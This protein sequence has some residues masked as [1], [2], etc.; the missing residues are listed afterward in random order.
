MSHPSG[1]ARTDVLG[2]TERNEGGRKKH[3]R[4]APVDTSL[5]VTPREQKR[6]GE[7]VHQR[8]PGVSPQSRNRD[9][10]KS[11][12][13]KKQHPRGTRN[14]LR[15]SWGPELGIT[16]VVGVGVEYKDQ[17]STLLIL[18]GIRKRS[19]GTPVSTGPTLSDKITVE[20]RSVV[21]KLQSETSWVECLLL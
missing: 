2:E 9:A 15:Q 7:G 19:Q 10:W 20:I 3:R 13:S 18:A 6:E 11:C 12:R 5:V 21:R 8:L 14:I 4:A 16:V 1:Y 17:Q